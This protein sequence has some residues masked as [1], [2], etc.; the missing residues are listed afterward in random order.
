MGYKMSDINIFLAPVAAGE[1][2]TLLAPAVEGHQTTIKL[3]RESTSSFIECFRKEEEK[4]KKEHK[5][6]APRQIGL[7]DLQ[8]LSSIYNW[9]V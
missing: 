1:M 3:K 6:F 5:A 9:F 7:F 4:Q 2:T 8:K